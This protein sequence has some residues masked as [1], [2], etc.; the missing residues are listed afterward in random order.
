M[1]DIKPVVPPTTIQ[2]PVATAGDV[3]TSLALQN[4]PSSTDPT[5]LSKPADHPYTAGDATVLGTNGDDFIHPAADTDASAT[6]S[7]VILG[8]AGNDLLI[9]GAGNDF[10]Y[11]SA[12][13]LVVGIGPQTPPGDAGTDVGGTPATDTI[14]GTLGNFNVLDGSAGDDHLFAGPGHDGFF[15]GNGSGHDVI[16]NF[17]VN[18][19]ELDFLTNLNQSGITDVDALATHMSDVGAAAGHGA[20]VQI[21]LSGGNNVVLE[22]VTMAA[23]TNPDLASTLFHFF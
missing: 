21:D 20:G 14:P 22:G 13:S 19:D 11:A 17:D 23:L 3:Y 2:P 16:H 4:N 1:A 6:T 10:L 9:G 5:F 8:G 15:F 7:H 18:H 12:F